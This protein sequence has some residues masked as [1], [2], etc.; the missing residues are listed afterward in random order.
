MNQSM[1]YA[2]NQNM[3][4]KSVMSLPIMSLKAT[5]FLS[6]LAFSAGVSLTYGVLQAIAQ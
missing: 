4:G 1:R 3:S 2:N 6:G 5:L